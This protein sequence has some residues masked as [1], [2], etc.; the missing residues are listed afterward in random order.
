MSLKL[1][2]KQENQPFIIKRAKI[3]SIIWCKVKF[4]LP[5]SAPWITAFEWIVVSE[6]EPLLL[7]RL[8][9][10]LMRVG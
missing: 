4:E 3:D 1:T 7:T 6:F 8:T 5:R 10:G 2:I 9:S